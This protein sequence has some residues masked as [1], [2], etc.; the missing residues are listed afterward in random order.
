MSKLE[1]IEKQIDDHIAA[2]C[3]LCLNAIRRV[4]APACP[5]LLELN[6]EAREVYRKASPRVRYQAAVARATR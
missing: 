4:D 5:F 3:Q 6:N 1:R 2:H